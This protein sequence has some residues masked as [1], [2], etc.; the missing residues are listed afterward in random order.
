MFA[1]FVNCL[2]NLSCMVPTIMT[3]EV[4]SATLSEYGWC[5]EN[6]YNY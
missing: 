6:A 3:T 2:F 1:L 5:F 4:K